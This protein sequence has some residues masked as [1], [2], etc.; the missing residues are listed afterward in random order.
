MGFSLAAV[1][2]GCFIV[3]FELLIVVASLVMEHRL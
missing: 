1:S 3:V 2:R